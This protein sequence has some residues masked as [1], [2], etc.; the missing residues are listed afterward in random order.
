M[1]LPQRR[2]GTHP[3]RE[4]L[5]SAA[6]SSRSKQRASPSLQN[7]ANTFQRAMPKVCCACVR[8]RV[9]ASAHVATCHIKAR[10]I[11]WQLRFAIEVLHDEGA[12]LAHRT[13]ERS[14]FVAI[15]LA[16]AMRA[17]EQTRVATACHLPAGSG[18]AR[19]RSSRLRPPGPSA[20]PSGNGSPK[21]YRGLAHPRLLGW[22]PCS[23]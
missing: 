17:S 19:R 7:E 2:D 15:V 9:G 21:S 6:L 12:Q 16:H 11:E 1:I 14:G 4:A 5:G 22:L 10:V 3:P 23:T 8:A 18:A 13:H 20:G